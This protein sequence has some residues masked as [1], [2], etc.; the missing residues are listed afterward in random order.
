MSQKRIE[1]PQEEKPRPQDDSGPKTDLDIDIGEVDDILQEIDI[2]QHPEKYTQEQRDCG[3]F[4][5]AKKG[6]GFR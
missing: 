5:P 4:T 3:C 6:G 1:R 2:I